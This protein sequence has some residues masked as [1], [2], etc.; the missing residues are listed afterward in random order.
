MVI[1]AIERG[2]GLCWLVPRDLRVQVIASGDLILCFVV[3]GQLEITDLLALLLEVRAREAHIC[4]YVV[5]ASVSCPFRARAIPAGILV[6]LA[7]H[8]AM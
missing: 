1:G 7:W 8:G 5:C 6:T 3:E 4:I 2:R